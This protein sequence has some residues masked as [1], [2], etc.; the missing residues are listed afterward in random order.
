MQTAL[1]LLVTRQTRTSLDLPGLGESLTGLARQPLEGLG[2]VP[3]LEAAR[4]CESQARWRLEVELARLEEEG[5]EAAVSVGSDLEARCLSYVEYTG[6]QCVARLN[7]LVAQLEREG[8]ALLGRE[9]EDCSQE[10]TSL[11]LG[12]A[13]SEEA[14]LGQLGRQEEQRLRQLY[15]EQGR[16][17]EAEVVAQ[18]EER[19]RQQE[20]EVRQEFLDRGRQE[21]DRVRTELEL[22]GRVMMASIELELRKRGE[23]EAASITKEFESR[24]AALEETIKAE[25]EERGAEIM[26]TVEAELRARGEALQDE[27]ETQCALMIEMACEVRGGGEGGFTVAH[28][29]SV[30][31]CYRGQ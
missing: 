10:V 18:F 17:L 6:Q 28:L 16:R 20:R 26:K 9:Q 21:E 13:T 29:T 24:G 12:L 2:Y 4:Q 30:L 1:L 15:E 3:V 11:S 27:G 8:R 7:S 31:G 23:K 22:R 25:F 14:R 5:V 19:G